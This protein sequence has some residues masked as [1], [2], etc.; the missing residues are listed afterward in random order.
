[1]PIT[2]DSKVLRTQCP[3]LEQVADQ[4]EALLKTYNHFI[5]AKIPATSAKTMLPVLLKKTPAEIK[6]CA[7][8][9]AEAIGSRFDAIQA[10][11]EE[12]TGTPV[13][14]REE[15]DAAILARL[16]GK[17]GELPEQNSNIAASGDALTWLTDTQNRLK[18]PLDLPQSSVPR[19]TP[20]KKGK[21]GKQIVGLFIRQDEKTVQAQPEVQQPVARPDWKTPPLLDLEDKDF[22]IL[23][24]VKTYL[25]AIPDQAQ[26]EQQILA[27]GWTPEVLSP[28]FGKAI[29][30]VQH[31]I[32]V[33]QEIIASSTAQ[34]QAWLSEIAGLK[35]VYEELVKPVSAYVNG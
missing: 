8:A 17:E 25:N 9:V 32:Q 31:Q 3:C 4:L 1:M 21:F 2:Y 28:I 30:E 34:A 14:D 35:A 7:S 29:S 20:V 13:K 6:S 24:T 5:A 22:T 26:A 33:S 19:D 10:E 23:T 15:L 18:V 11:F 16:N 27:L 12:K